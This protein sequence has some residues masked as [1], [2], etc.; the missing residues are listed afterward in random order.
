MSRADD[1]RAG[2]VREREDRRGGIDPGKSVQIVV[3]GK[4]GSGKTELAH[5][6]Y[7]SWPFDKLVVDPNHDIKV[8]EDTIELGDAP[9][10][11]WPPAAELNARLAE[12][13]LVERRYHSLRVTPDHGSPTFE[14]DIDRSIG[15]VY[16]HPG[17]LAFVDEAH[18]AAPV[19][20]MHKHPHMRRALTTGRHARMS[21]ILATPRVLGIT[22]LCLM[23]ADWVYVFRLPHPADRRRV[24]Q[25]IGWTQKLFDEAHN[26][27]GDYE[28][29]RYE[30]GANGGAGELLIFPALPQKLIRHHNA[31]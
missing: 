30:S 29:L 19:N 18:Y 20:H 9:P 24:A 12:Q 22:V 10:A 28:Y 16:G 1:R 2:L 27:L 31:A 8:D 3:V 26:S 4:K 15:L 5:V 14:D 23:Q 17:S 13:D 21:M 11:H 25:S 6:L 7:R